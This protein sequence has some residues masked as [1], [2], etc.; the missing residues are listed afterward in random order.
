MQRIKRTVLTILLIAAVFSGT[1]AGAAATNLPAGMLIGDQNGIHVDAQGEYFI[2]ADALEAGDV[3]TKRLTIQNTEPYSYKLSMTAEPL[4]ETGP[5]RLLDE[6]RCTLKLD[7]KV[8]YDGRVRGNDGT[9]MIRNALDL[10]TYQTG[11]QKTLDITLTVNRDMRKYYW[12][13]SEAYFKWNFYAAQDTRPD[14]PK[15]GETVKNSLYAIL[16][17]M[18]LAMGILLLIKRRRNGNNRDELIAS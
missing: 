16:P 12:T 6:V 1:A 9:D 7:G 3:I 8:L 4:E 5:L 10:G 13:A 2:S 11:E 17:A 15:T 14:G 18:A